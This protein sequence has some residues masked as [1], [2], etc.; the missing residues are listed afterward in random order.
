MLTPRRT[1]ALLAAA[2]LA[3]L[4][5]TAPATASTALPHLAEPATTTSLAATVGGAGLASPGV[6]VNTAVPALPALPDIAAA[7]WLVADLD[8]GE[9]LAAK[10]PHGRFAPASTLKTLTALTLLPLLDPDRRVVPTFEDVNVEGSKVGI[11][12]RV[13][14]PVHE[15]FSALLMVSGNDAANALATVAGGQRKTA[16]L[17]NAKATELGARDTFVVN[18]HGLDAPGQLSSA[19]DLALI[20]RAGLAN[21]DFA[22]YVTTKTS[23]IS[24]PGGARISMTNKNKLLRDY[25]G[26]LGVKNGFTN[27]AR[28]SFV[29]AAERDGRRLVVTM[30]KATPNVFGEATKL[31]DWGFAAQGAAPIGVLVPASNLEEPA[32]VSP[33]QRTGG[34]QV[35]LPADKNGTGLPA[36]VAGMALAAAALL[37]VRRRP[38]ATAPTRRASRPAPSQPSEARIPVGAGRGS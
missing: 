17:M 6:V 24:A 5:L 16:E 32:P 8:T 13:A 21:P 15:L 31:L 3:V 28:A 9:V 1:P 20:A 33:A 19:Y 26:A 10:D 2:V 18:P 34:P 23:S 25:P 11:V 35:S 27:A 36:T 14:Y 30:L 22:R 12:Q 7:S 37:V 38:R 29:G 4:A